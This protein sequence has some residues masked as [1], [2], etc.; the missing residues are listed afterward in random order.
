MTEHVTSHGAISPEN[1]NA[2][3]RSKVV[4]VD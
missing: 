4:K 2:Q 1:A 3:Q